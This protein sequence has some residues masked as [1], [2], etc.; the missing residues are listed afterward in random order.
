MANDNIWWTWQIIWI[1]CNDQKR[2]WIKQTWSKFISKSI[3]W[4]SY[5]RQSEWRITSQR[6]D[7][8]SSIT[9]VSMNDDSWKTNIFRQ[10]SSCINVKINSFSRYKQLF[11]ILRLIIWYEWFFRR[12]FLCRLFIFDWTVN[13][14][15]RI[16]FIFLW[17]FKSRHVLRYCELNCSRR[18]F[19]I[20][21][22]SNFSRRFIHWNFICSISHCCI[23]IV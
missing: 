9:L 13:S 21:M 23:R 4:S 3:K 17:L 16:I 10:K 5:F 7:E 11:I 19:I 8:R 20:I 2:S 22:I 1:N 6:I 14:L 12:S 15:Q 18:L